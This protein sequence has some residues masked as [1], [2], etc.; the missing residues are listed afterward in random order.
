MEIVNQKHRFSA[1]FL[2]S[3]SGPVIV[4]AWVCGVWV[5]DWWSLLQVAVC[6][7]E[8]VKMLAGRPQVVGGLAGEG[9]R[10][11]RPGQ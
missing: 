7:V 5:K 9:A 2:E 4:V 1:K 8:P 11:R 6:V 3:C 10:L